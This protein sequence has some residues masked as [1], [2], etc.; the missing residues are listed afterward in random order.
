M[1][2][3]NVHVQ[4]DP[5]LERGSLGPRASRKPEKRLILGFAFII[6]KTLKN[7]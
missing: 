3:G 4:I 2:L 7:R 6:L 5:R 1:T